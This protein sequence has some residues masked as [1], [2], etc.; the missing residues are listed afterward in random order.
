[1]IFDFLILIWTAFIIGVLINQ[2]A[3]PLMNDQKVFPA[4][5]NNE[6]RSKVVEVR[7]QVVNL[8]DQ[9]KNLKELEGLINARNELEKQI[10]AFDVEI[11]K[12]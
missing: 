4:F 1:M 11:K 12:E 6:L 3:L 9:N 5:R 10:A 8:R 2:V 7:E